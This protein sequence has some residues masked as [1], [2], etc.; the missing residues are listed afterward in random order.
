MLLP[1]ILVVAHVGRAGLTAP[2]VPRFAIAP[3]C[4]SDLASRKACRRDE[5]EA[6]AALQRRWPRFSSADRTSCTHLARIGGPPGYVGLLA[7]LQTAE[8]ADA[9]PRSDRLGRGIGR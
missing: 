7:C 5:R 3:A 1:M 8:A 4:R 9:L 2:P 6:R